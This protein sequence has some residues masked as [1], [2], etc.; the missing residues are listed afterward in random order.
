VL[1]DRAAATATG[2]PPHPVLAPG[3]VEAPASINGVTARDFV[4]TV[5]QELLALSMNTL[6]SGSR[7]AF[8]HTEQWPEKLFYAYHAAPAPVCVPA[9]LLMATRGE[10]E[11]GSSCCNCAG[12]CHRC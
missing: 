5:L 2:Y 6:S 3:C 11:W 10:C 12:V 9:G 8:N 1:S 7:T 4:R